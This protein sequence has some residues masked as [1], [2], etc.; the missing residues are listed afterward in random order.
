MGADPIK[1]KFLVVYEYGMGAVWAYILAQSRKNLSEAFPQLRIVD[2]PPA[3]M[4]DADL[5]RIQQRMT[6][7]IDDTSDPF[8]RELRQEKSK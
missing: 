7:D 3:W 6:I 8:L 4:T 1:K 2:S 5:E